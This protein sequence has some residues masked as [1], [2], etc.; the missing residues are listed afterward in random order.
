MELLNFL[1]KESGKSFQSIVLIAVISGLANALLL[2]IINMAT[3]DKNSKSNTV[4]FFIL[5][6]VCITLFIFTKQFV[7]KKT[8]S[9]VEEVIKNL[10]IRIANKI[11]HSDLLH[12][13]ETG[14]SEIFT[15]IS[16]DATQISQAVTFAGNA[17]Q[18]II[19]V[20]FSVI[21]IAFVSFPSFLIVVSSLILG[22]ISYLR[23]RKAA[24]DLL[25]RA[26]QKEAEFYG[27]LNELLLGFKEIKINRKK[28]EAVFLNF[29]DI[30]VESKA[31]K[32]QAILKLIVS[33]IA[34][35]SFFYCLL[36]CIIFL[37]PKYVQIENKD[38]IKIS[39]AILFIIGPLESIVSSVPLLF[40]ANVAASNIIRLEN[41]LNNYNDSS[42]PS[43]ES[44]QNTLPLEFNNELNVNNI[45]F[46]YPKKDTHPPFG[47]GPVNLKIRKGM[48]TFITGGNGS[49]KSTFLKLLSGLYYYQDGYIVVDNTTLNTQNYQAYRELF[50]IIFTDFH[51]FQKLYGLS[52]YDQK[53]INE[54]LAEMQID[55]K[56]QI[57][58]GNI[59]NIQLST[60]QK[61]RLALVVSI[62][63]DK[64]IYIFD[65][66]AADQ[67][68]QFKTYFYKTFLPKLKEKGKTIIAVTHDEYY[69]G[70][71]DFRYKIENGNFI[72]VKDN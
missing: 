41:K 19:M 4:I 13:E 17:F 3:S 43:R 33:Y 12:L 6:L 15:R 25:T 70:D 67:D 23:Y 16:Q 27:S 56:T 55:K 36:A 34:S 52:E 39:A 5:Y 26:S 24:T 40:T 53:I 62:L 14:T 9:L 71:C 57:I 29:R 21:Y 1:R 31:L 30:A 58:D 44:E 10:R 64:S 46:T 45:A 48:I 22:A 32:V 69:F 50:S 18:S 8:A 61:K 38:L 72:A 35:E 63:D 59:S 7:L 37:L 65:E 60:G 54:L 28:N 42:D 11:R 51:L 68:P 49:G 20:T 47:I 66:V 2:A